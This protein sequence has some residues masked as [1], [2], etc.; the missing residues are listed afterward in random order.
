MAVLIAE[1]P[2]QGGRD[3]DDRNQAQ[4]DYH[5]GRYCFAFNAFSLGL[6]E[7]S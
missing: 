6:E 3:Q 5:E 2:N 7:K 4:K 1:L